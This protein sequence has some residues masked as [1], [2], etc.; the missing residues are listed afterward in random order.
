MFKRVLSDAH[1]LQDLFDAWDSA[2][3][4]ARVAWQ[5]WLASAPRDRG[6]AYAG[7]CASLDREEHAAA[8]LAA[9]VDTSSRGVL[10]DEVRIAA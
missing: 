3:H 10:A 4:D 6:A 8:L 2:A 1:R 5:T 7:Y 9:A